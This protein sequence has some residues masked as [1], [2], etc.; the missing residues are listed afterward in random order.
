MKKTEA[1]EMGNVL[2]I[3]ADQKKKE[4]EQLIKYITDKQKK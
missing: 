3:L 2:L 4:K 1:I